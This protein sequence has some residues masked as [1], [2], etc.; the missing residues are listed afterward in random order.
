MALA[1][2]L[3]AVL[4]AALMLPTP[5]A[6]AA[7]IEAEIVP[8]SDRLTTDAYQ[9]YPIEINVGDT[10]VWTNRD[11]TIHTV[12][13]G[14]PTEGATGEFGG[15]QENPVLVFAN[16]KFSHTFETEGEFDYYCTLHPSM[17]GRVIVGAAD[18]GEPT[19]PE[20][21][22]A[23][24]EHEGITYTVTAMSAE[25]TVT[26]VEIVPEES[27]RVQFS[28]PG[29]VELTLST[30]MVSGITVVNSVEGEVEFTEVDANDESTTISFT[31][32]DSAEVEIFAAM[33]VPEFGVIA[34]LV[35]AGSL[36]AV[37]SFARFRG[38]S[39]GLGRF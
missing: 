27:I 3:A 35:L 10:V 15:T 1:A 2:G 24:A 5:A 12:T 34:A 38:S 26:G 9:P 32:P 21:S 14:T 29:Q 22:T 25:T 31:V 8:G 23:T 4:V 7:T 36:V 39:I 28:A 33:V 30:D 17:V 37:V 19:E 18:N 20:E 6:F 13:A 11:N 16:Q